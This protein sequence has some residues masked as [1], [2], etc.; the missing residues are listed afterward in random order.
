MSSVVCSTALLN[1]S[2]SAPSD[3]LLSCTSLFVGLLESL[4]SPLPLPPPPVSTSSSKQNVDRKVDQV[5]QQDFDA[6]KPGGQHAGEEMDDRELGE[7]QDDED[8]EIKTENDQDYETVI[9]QEIQSVEEIKHQPEKVKEE[10]KIEDTD[11]PPVLDNISLSRTVCLPAK[12]VKTVYTESDDKPNKL[13]KL[14][15]VIKV[16]KCV[17][18]KIISSLCGLCR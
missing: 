1:R 9:K 17:A 11:K 10:S 3:E 5:K 7:I 13:E 2:S 4:C 12:L 6:V 16:C 14:I 15:S 8:G 18:V